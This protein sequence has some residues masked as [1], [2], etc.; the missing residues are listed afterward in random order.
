MKDLITINNNGQPVAS[1][2]DIAEHFEKRH[3]HVVR[4]IDAFS[5]DVPNFG[6]MFFSVEIPDSYGRPQR[7][8]LMNR[9]GF[10]LLVMGFTGKSALEWKLKYIDAFNRMEAQIKNPQLSPAEQLLAQ[11]QLMVEQERR[12]KALENR[13]ER[14]EQTMQKTLDIFSAPAVSPDDWTSA[15]NHQIN[16]LVEQYGG[17]HRKFRSDRYAELEL[18]TG[19]DLKCRQTR[20]RNRMRKNGATETEC[21]QVSILQVISR[22]RKLR[23]AFEAIIRRK[24]ASLIS[25]AQM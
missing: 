10:S 22:D 24:A 4:D 2:R 11:A 9:D 16:T 13:A 8:Y 15:M 1:S 7:A 3:D 23:P 25:D 18:E 21:K 19:V 5:K 6:E 14:T 20:L 17:N 12:L